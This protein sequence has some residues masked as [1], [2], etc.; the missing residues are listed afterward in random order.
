MKNLKIT[1]LLAL[2][3]AAAV[4]AIPAYAS[5]PHTVTAHS[6]RRHRGSSHKMEDAAKAVQKA[7]DKKDLDAL[8]RV[9]NFPLEISFTDGEM[10]TIKD[11]KALT[12]FGSDRIFTKTLCDAI[13]ST[14][15][16]KLKEVGDA[17]VQMGDDNGLNLYKFKGKWKVNSIY[18]DLSSKDDTINSTDLGETAIN[19]QKCFSYRDLETLSKFCNYPL[20]IIKEDGTLLDIKDAKA[21]LA[22]GENK[23]FTGKLSEAIDKVDSSKLAAVGDAGVQMGGDSGLTLYSFNGMWKINNIYQ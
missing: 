12:D 11:K 7:F 9:S 23:V 21:F 22:L 2:S 19:I 1:M 4:P 3:L 6:E 14:N 15:L 16:A 8:A 17:G 18:T 10:V 5:S 13:A 20:V